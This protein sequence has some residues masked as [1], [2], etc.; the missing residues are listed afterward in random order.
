MVNLKVHNLEIKSQLNE[1]YR[2]DNFIKDDTNQ[3]ARTLEPKAGTGKLKRF[4]NHLMF[5][6]SFEVI[7]K[8]MRLPIFH[9][10][11]RSRR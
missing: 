11:E 10:L 2:F 7:L 5:I 6:L 4:V 9:I 1:N 8:L 3:D